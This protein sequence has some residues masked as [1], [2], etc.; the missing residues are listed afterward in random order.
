MKYAIIESGGKQY[1]ATEGSVIDVDLLTVEDGAKIQLDQV[2]LL[3]DG[4]KVSVGAPVVSGA[5][6]SAT[7]QGMVKGPKVVVFKYRPKKRYRVK[8]GH[9][10]RYTRLVINSIEV[11]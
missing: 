1:K 2:L 4:D 7:V 8:T 9:R 5:R 10:E 6:I 11:E 3:V